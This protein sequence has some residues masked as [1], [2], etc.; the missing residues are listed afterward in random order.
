MTT[1]NLDYYR[2]RADEELAAAERAVDPA[3]AQIHH[4]MAQRYRDLLGRD[5]GVA[6]PMGGAFAGTGT[7]L[8]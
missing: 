2:Q 1:H 5:A 3:I 8:A 4:D 6:E 7:V